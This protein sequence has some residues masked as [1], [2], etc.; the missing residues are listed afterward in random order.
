M[1]VKNPHRQR[2]ERIKGCKKKSFAVS[3]EPA[4][5]SPA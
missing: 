4:E 5:E 3:G 1:L 2:G